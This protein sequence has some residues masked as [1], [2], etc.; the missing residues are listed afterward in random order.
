[1]RRKEKILFLR[2]AT[3]DETKA[4]FQQLIRDYGAGIIS[5]ED[6]AAIGE[7][8]LYLRKDETVLAEI[9]YNQL[10]GHSREIALEYLRKYLRS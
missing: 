3:H 10:P 6:A 8:F 4:A 7:V 2:Q 5:E 9:H 1:M